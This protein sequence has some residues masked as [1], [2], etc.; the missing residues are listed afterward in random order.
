MGGT[1][2]VAPKAVAAGERPESGEGITR[3]TEERGAPGEGV[4]SGSEVGRTPSTEP[5]GGREEPGSRSGR[6]AAV[7]G[8]KIMGEKGRATVR[9][10]L[11]PP[12]VRR[13]E[14]RRREREVPLE[15]WRRPPA[16]EP[17]APTPP[18]YHMHLSMGGQM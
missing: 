5:S 11:N 12:E 14:R 4:T 17:P 8:E 18:S 7:E 1:C 15:M 9:D 16:R 2:E 6:G 10:Q 13:R 3:K